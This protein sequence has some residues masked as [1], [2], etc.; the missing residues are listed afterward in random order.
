VK[1]KLALITT[2]VALVASGNLHAENQWGLTPYVGADVQS[3]HMNWGKGL[4]DNLFAHDAM[5]GNVY[6]GVKFNEYFGV[7]GGY[8]STDK[9]D[10]NAKLSSGDINAGIPVASVPFATLQYITTSRIS[11]HHI[12]VTASAPISDEYRLKVLG[13]VGIASLKA[14]L[15]RHTTSFVAGGIPLPSPD[16]IFSKRKNLLRLGAGLEHMITETWG[17]RAS[18]IWENTNRL[19]V[20]GVSRSASPT[21]QAKNSLLYSA[22]AFFNF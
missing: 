9:K 12:S 5:Q 18:L 19:K 7:E 13:I 17:V 22:G 3:R 10:R 11:G 2:S 4:G 6:V 15:F 20:S 8:E 16:V 14:S 21:V 1:K